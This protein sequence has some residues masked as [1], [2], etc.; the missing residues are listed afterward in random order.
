MLALDPDL[1]TELESEG[2]DVFWGLELPLGGNT[3]KLAERPANY[4]GEKYTDGIDGVTP[5]TSSM[6]PDEKELNVQQLDV[7]VS[8]FPGALPGGTRLHHRFTQELEAAKA[9]VDLFA[10]TEHVLDPSTGKRVGIPSSLR[11]QPLFVGVP[12]GLTGWT[13]AKGT[14]R[15]QPYSEQ[16]LGKPLCEPITEED[17]GFAR[18]ADIGKVIPR[19][20]GFVEGAVGRVTKAAKASLPV[21]GIGNTGSGA[22]GRPTVNDGASARDYTVTISSPET[23][24]FLGPEDVTIGLGTQ[25]ASRVIQG[26]SFQTAG[27][28]LLRAIKVKIVRLSGSLSPWI[29]VFADSGGSPPTVIGSGLGKGYASVTNTSLEWKTF[30]FTTPIPLTGATTYHWTCGVDINSGSPS[31]SLGLAGVIAGGYAGGSVKTGSASLPTSSIVSWATRGDYPSMDFLFELVFEETDPN[32]SVTADPG[33]AQGSGTVGDDFVTSNGEVNIPGSRWSGSPAAGDTFTFS[34]DPADNEVVF[35]D[36]PLATPCAA[37]AKLRIN[38][39]AVGTGATVSQLSDDAGLAIGRDPSTAV[40]GGAAQTINLL[41]GVYRWLTVKLERNGTPEANIRISLRRQGFNGVEYWSRELEPGDVSTSPTLHVLGFDEPIIWPGGTAY[42]IVETSG[43]DDSNYYRVRQQTSTDPYADGALFYWDRVAGAWKIF[44]GGDDDMY[45]SIAAATITLD[46]QASDYA[47]RQVA[48]ANFDE[49]DIPD[50]W[51]IQAD[52]TGVTDDSDGIY[53]GVAG[54]LITIPADVIHYLAADAG[55]PTEHIDLAGSFLRSRALAGSIYRVNGV[56]ESAGQDTKAAM[57]QLAFENRSEVDWSIDKLEFRFR[58]LDPEVVAIITYDDI[59]KGGSAED[60]IPR[61][62]SRRTDFEDVLNDFN[63]RYQRNWAK[64]KA[65]DAYRRVYSDRNEESFA[66]FGA[67]SR[68]EDLMC[69]FI[70][71]EAHAAGLVGFLIATCGFVDDEHEVALG[72]DWIKIKKGEG[73]RFNLPEPSGEAVANY[74]DQ[75]TTFVLREHR[76]DLPRR[77]LIGI[78]REV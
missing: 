10:Y 18:E 72:L 5:V 24:E 56:F 45:F 70:T 37:L 65:K 8:N 76:I 6:E 52:V 55:L 67:R 34:V 69:D 63:L 73:A 62:E 23:V 49:L 7:A 38:G 17:Y 35:A 22:L 54:A 32:Y 66:A 20:F 59:L 57:L 27:S 71:T 64:A 15:L 12:R 77:E 75:Q 42:L 51:L 28:Q 3:L 26:Q 43:S 41:A 39:V 68:D 61:I 50:S 1:Q 74:I 53:T 19:V 14:M 78:F 2:P 36:S 16:F 11:R 13:P 48:R 33:G 46:E 31:N 9:R 30:T 4:F 29:T 21:P 58:E 60:P 44:S 47:G 40:H 25:P